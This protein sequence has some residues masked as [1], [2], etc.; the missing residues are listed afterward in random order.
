[1]H[2]GALELCHTIKHRRPYPNLLSLDG[3]KRNRSKNFICFNFIS[4]IFRHIDYM[5]LMISGWATKFL[6]LVLSILNKELLNGRIRIF[7]VVVAVMA[8]I[9]II[10]AWN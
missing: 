8:L 4:V 2:S 6:L 5:S 3:N 10:L 9:T 1:M 7:L